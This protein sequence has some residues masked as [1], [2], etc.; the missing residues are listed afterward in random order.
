MALDINWV[1]GVIFIPRA[2]MPIVQSTPVEVRS[3]DIPQFH[4]DLRSIHAS[5]QG[6]PYPTTHTHILTYTASGLIV[7]EATLIL[8]PY[9]VV[10]EAGLY[11]VTALDANS[12][13]GDRIIPNGVTFIGN[14]STG[15]LQGS[16]DEGRIG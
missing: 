5:V 15:P 12:N 7:P 9:T 10:F 4:R 13:I 6:A 8:P 2:D 11:V 14:N 1:T 3:L 16:V